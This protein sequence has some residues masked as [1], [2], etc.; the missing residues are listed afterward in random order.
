VSDRIPFAEVYAGDRCIGI[1]E[2]VVSEP[3]E[4]AEPSPPDGGNWKV[5]APIPLP[6]WSPEHRERVRQEVRAKPLIVANV[7][8]VTRT[9]DQATLF[10]AINDM[11]RSQSLVLMVPSNADG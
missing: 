10:D 1:A 8:A 7:P 6:P 3:H 2:D 11:L 4:P 9:P 5:C